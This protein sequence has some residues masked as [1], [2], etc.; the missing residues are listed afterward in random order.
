MLRMCARKALEA[1]QR[2]SG[3]GKR[4]K[5]QGWRLENRTRGVAGG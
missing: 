4:A 5:R 2:Y 3:D 1:L